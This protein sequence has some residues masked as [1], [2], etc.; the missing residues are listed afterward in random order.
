MFRFGPD[1]VER[2]CDENGLDMIV[3]AHECVM[4]GFER[5]ARGR[6]VTVF[7]A[8]DYQKI[9]NSAA[10]LFIDRNLR[11]EPRVLQVAGGTLFERQ[12]AA[13]AA[14]AAAAAPARAEEEAKAADNPA[15]KDEPTVFQG[16]SAG[17][18]GTEDNDEGDDGAS[19]P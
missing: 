2:F 1:V 8:V 12:M 9:G 6:L 7:S 18:N 11:I 10:V 19:Q 16:G 13:A 4:D 14:A 5:F 3:R 17:D 15:A